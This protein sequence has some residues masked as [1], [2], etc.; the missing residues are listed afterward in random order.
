MG[1]EWEF[2]QLNVRR[3]GDVDRVLALARA[4]AAEKGVE[5]LE[6][7]RPPKAFPPREPKPV[8]APTV[9]PGAKAVAPKDQPAANPGGSK[10]E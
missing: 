7:Q 1:K 2:S 9:P 8:P 5:P 6:K 3:A 10:S 4:W